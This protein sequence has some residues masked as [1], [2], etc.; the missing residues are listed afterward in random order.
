MSGNTSTQSPVCTT[1]ILTSPNNWDKWIKVIKTKAKAR[2]IWNYVNPSKE[3]GEVMTLSRLE[4]P[5][6]KDVNP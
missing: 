2:K 4:I 5:M 1:V 6:A 3:K